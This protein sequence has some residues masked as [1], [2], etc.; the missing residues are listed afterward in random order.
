MNTV[1]LL[2]KP[3]QLA[4]AVMIQHTLFSLPFAVGVLVL[5]SKGEIPWM[6]ALWIVLAIFGARNGANALNRLADHTIDGENPRTRNRHL[7]SGKLKRID[8]WILTIGCFALLLFSTAMLGWLPLVLLP[9]AA[10]MIIIYSYSKRFTWLC[11]FLLGATVAIAPMGTLIALTGTIAW[12]FFPIPIGVALW[13]AGFDIIYGCQ[14]IHFDRSAGLYS[15]PARFGQKGALLISTLSHV[16]T[17]FAFASL[18]LF[19]PLSPIFWSGYTLIAVLL[20]IEHAIVAPN[21]LKHIE[22]ASY[23]INEIVGVVFMI[24]LILEVYLQ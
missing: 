16:G 5:E 18:G 4:D 23:H 7:P 24:T 10:L 20:I 11:H 9:G 14:D 15:I 19:Y 8:L 12:R 17:L 6:K 3:K 2:K 13:V 22:K 21:E 1:S